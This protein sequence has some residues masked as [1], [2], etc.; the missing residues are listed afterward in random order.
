MPRYSPDDILDLEAPTDHFLCPLSANTYGIDFKYFSICDY[1]SKRLIFEVGG[2]VPAPPAPVLD[3]ANLDEMSYRQI[4]YNF[5]EDVLRLPTIQ[6][7]LVFSV[8]PQELEEFRMIERHYFRDQLIKSYDFTFGFVIPNSTNTWDAV[9][10]LPPM[11][12]SLLDDIIANPYESTSDSF[13]F[14]GD[15]LVMHNKAQYKY[16]KEA[17]GGAQEKGGSGGGAG[18]KGGSKGGG[19]GGK[20]EKSYKGS[21]NMGFDAEAAE[22]K[23][24]KASDYNTD[25]Y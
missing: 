20:A 5:S 4:K 11:D 23:W 9:Y 12:D 13:Y 24:S 6:T 3:Y 22:S 2:D 25:Y 16:S 14:V 15:D 17:A 21:K 18:Y 10:S 7:S 19:G 8:G 1:E